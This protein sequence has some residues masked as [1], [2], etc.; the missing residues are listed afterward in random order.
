MALGAHFTPLPLVFQCSVL[1]VFKAKATR[2]KK[3]KA[4]DVRVT[5]DRTGDFK[6]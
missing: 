1:L 5:E 6:L 4:A 3:L 2:I